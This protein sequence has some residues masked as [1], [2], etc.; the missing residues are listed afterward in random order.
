MF[1]CQA[2]KA[3]H[4]ELV[5][6]LSTQS[7]LAALRRVISRRGKPT[8]ICSDNATNFVG[9]NNEL[10]KLVKLHSNT[11]VNS[12]AHGGKDIEWKFIPPIS[13]HF[14]GLW[15]ENIKIVKN[16][17]SKVIGQSILTFEEFCTLLTQVEAI[18]NSRP[19]SPL[20]NDPIDLNPLTP[21]HFLIGRNIM[22][23]PDEQ[24]INTPENYLSSFQKIQ[25]KT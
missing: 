3:V 22:A 5:S 11:I 21:A 17:L 24:L 20:S 7:F 8:Q 18:V 9:A 1:I 6:D 14:G 15:E 19:I 4:L 2:R 13:P 12:L 10:R 23:A 25:R 16:H